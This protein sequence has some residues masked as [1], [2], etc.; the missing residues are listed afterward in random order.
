M[1][2][3]AEDN[4]ILSLKIKLQFLFKLN[5]KQIHKNIYSTKIRDLKIFNW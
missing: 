3:Y 4:T 2:R 5:E 1:W